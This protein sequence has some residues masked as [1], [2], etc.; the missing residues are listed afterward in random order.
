MD[1]LTLQSSAKVNLS[2][3]VLGRRA[4]GYHW[5]RTIL[6][7][8]GLFDTLHF[9]R[10]P[11]DIRLHCNWA[12]LATPA[13]LCWR[14]AELL[15]AE[16]GTTAGVSIALEK[17]IPL[18]SG[19]GGG[20]GNAA[21]TLSA[22]NQL[23]ALHLS[24]EA[25]QRLA[26]RLGAD[27]PFFLRGGCALAE[28]VGERLTPLPNGLRAWLVLVQPGFALATREVYAWWDAAGRRAE[29]PAPTG[30]AEAMIVA[31]QSGDVGEIGRHVSNALEAVVASRF[32]EIT[33][34][35]TQLLECGATGATMTGTGSVVFGIFADASLAWAAARHVQTGQRQVFVVPTTP[36]SVVFVG[37]P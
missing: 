2:L 11:G 15:R 5:V 21:A 27:V 13:N 4:D 32:P 12:G 8:V 18:G 1:T 14:A 19:L 37:T 22:L 9:T 36:T 23:W 7:S 25:L 3:D 30:S 34:I 29:T 16:T 10:T 24:E 26:A 20:S 17:R 28:G 31:L 35:K 6:Q 33:V